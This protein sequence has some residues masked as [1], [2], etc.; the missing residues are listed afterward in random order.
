VPPTETTPASYSW[1]TYEEIYDITQHLAHVIFKKGF[2]SEIDDTN[3]TFYEEEKGEIKKG[4]PRHLKVLGINSVNC[5]Q[6]VTTDLAAN[7]LGITTV[8]LYE[9]LGTTMMQ[10]ILE[11]TQM[12]TIFGSDKCLLNILKLAEE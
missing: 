8:P 7:L 11:Q 6:W 1:K 10:L 3:P 4:P 5:E 9:T 12:S 2:Y